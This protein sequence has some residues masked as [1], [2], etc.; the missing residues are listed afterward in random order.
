MPSLSDKTK[1]NYNNFV[2][3]VLV[4]N[5]I[6]YLQRFRNEF[7]SDDDTEYYESWLNN[8][9]KREY[10]EVDLNFSLDRSQSY[11][12]LELICVMFIQSIILMQFIVNCKELPT[13]ENLTCK[14]LKRAPKLISLIFEE[15][16]WIDQSLSSL[17][18][19][20]YGSSLQHVTVSLYD[21]DE[22][23]LV[24]YILKAATTLKEMTIMCFL[25]DKIKIL[26]KLLAFPRSSP[27]CRIKVLFPEEIMD[28]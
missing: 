20:G 24:K 7:S 11:K 18:N 4:E 12:F 25:E 3:K 28:S 26:Q 6:S 13:F 19:D 10:F 5:D 8:A 15:V 2:S 1:I 23:S 14:L 21:F 17:A 16:E 27:F 22:V 9:K